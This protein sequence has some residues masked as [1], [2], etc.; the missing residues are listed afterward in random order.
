MYEPTH[1]LN[2]FQMRPRSDIL[3]GGHGKKILAH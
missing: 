1:L 3:C 2:R